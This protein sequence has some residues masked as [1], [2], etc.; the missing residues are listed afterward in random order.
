MIYLDS[1]STSKVSKEVI[2]EMLPFF[3]V[4]FQN[5]SSVHKG[6]RNIK[7]QIE[8]SRELCA[9]LINANPNEII[10]TSGATEAIN[11][12]LKGY[13]EENYEKG[14]HIITCKTE[15]NAVLNTCKYLETKG[16]EVTYLD[17]DKNG[18]INLE[19]L[20]NSIR[21]NTI[22]IALMYVNNE[23]GTL[24]DIKEI[25]KIAEQSDIVLFTDATQA[26]GKINIDVNEM[27]IGMLSM[28][29]HKIN[30]PKGIG[31][32]YK[33]EDINLTPLIHGGSQENNLR[34]GTYNSPLIIGLGKACEIATKNFE[35]NQDTL[36]K[37]RKYFENKVNE[38]PSL[39]IIAKMGKRSN[40]IVNLKAKGLDAHV[41][42]DK[43]EGVEVSN[44]SACTSG[45]IEGSHVLKAMGYSDEECS[46]CVRVSFDHETELCEIDYFIKKITQ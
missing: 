20:K 35:K 24:H 39:E 23:T 43:S 33:R 34:A 45:I 46:N 8:K 30:G 44:G 36:L 10:F 27:N 22:L 1:A 2:N 5:A 17:V 19:K 41:F 13:V 21:P 15:H 37:I 14:N 3:D 26:I 42:I 31:F 25:G 32:L 29:A 16:V 38:I 7:I 28:S 11:L 4:H 12:A 9:N 40:N 6:G 18:H